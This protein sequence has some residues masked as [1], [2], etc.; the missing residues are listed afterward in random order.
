MYLYHDNNIVLPVKL[1][2]GFRAKRFFVDNSR[3]RR[4]PVITYQQDRTPTSTSIQ[5]FSFRYKRKKHFEVY[6]LNNNKS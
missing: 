4:L 2:V 1:I 5:N 6:F 3:C